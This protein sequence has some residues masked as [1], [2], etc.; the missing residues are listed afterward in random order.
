MPAGAVEFALVVGML[1]AYLRAGVVDT[2]AAAG[3]KVRAGIVD[4]QKPAVLVLVHL[5]VEVRDL[6]QQH[7]KVFHRTRGL[8][9]LGQVGAAGRA[10]A[11]AALVVRGDLH[12]GDGGDRDNGRH[13]GL[14]GCG[15]DTKPRIIATG[16]VEDEAP[17]TT[18]HETHSRL[19][20][21]PVHG[22]FQLAK[23]KAWFLLGFI[24]KRLSRLKMAVPPCT[25]PQAVE[26][27]VFQQP[28][29]PFLEYGI[30]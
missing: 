23:Q 12:R 16:A 7:V 10:P 27:L 3:L 9:P 20:K 22:L 29:V 13:D 26:K 24:F 6:P 18:I 5:G 4:Q 25:A 21:K 17:G 28:A 14:C 1:A 15:S 30:Q 19:L 8:D 2:A 11:E